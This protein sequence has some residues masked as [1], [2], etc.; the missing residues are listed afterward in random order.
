MQR[1]GVFTLDRKSAKLLVKAR[2]IL[3][4]LALLEFY[5]IRLVI[6]NNQ[7]IFFIIIVLVVES[8]GA[9][10]LGLKWVFCKC[11]GIIL[12]IFKIIFSF[13]F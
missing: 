6:E 9:C 4:K 5:W 13:A 10:S 8:V 3:V 1:L 7:R 12:E 11:L 2:I